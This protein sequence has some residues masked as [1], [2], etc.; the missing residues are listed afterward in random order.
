MAGQ[1]RGWTD[2]DIEKIIGNLLRAGVI[3]AAAVVLAG[4]V[5]YVARH[6]HTEPQYGVFHGEPSDLRN[7]S[8]I[9]E[10]AISLHGRGLIQLGLLLLIATP[11]ARVA[12]SVIAFAVERDWLYV[13]ITLIVLGVLVYSL[14][15]S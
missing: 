8:Q 4:G 7:V 5:L 12:F 10:Q 9:F 15:S 2:E 13:V 3:L 1:V 11:V 6:G 14:T